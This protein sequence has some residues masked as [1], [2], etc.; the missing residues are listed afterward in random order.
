MNDEDK[1]KVFV[2]HPDPVWREVAN[3]MIHA[4]IREEGSPF[5]LEQLWCR[6]LSDDRF[7]ICCIPFFS[8]DLALADEVVTAPAGDHRYVVREVAK[9]SGHYTFRVWFPECAN[10]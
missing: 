1:S 7:I 3:F 5:R 9:P 10:S 6:Q 4:D 2:T 8:Y